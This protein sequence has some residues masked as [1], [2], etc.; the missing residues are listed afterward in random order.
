MFQ[1]LS[2][3]LSNTIYYFWST[4]NPLHPNISMHILHTVLSCADRENLF[5][6]Q[7]VLQFIIIAFILITL[8]FDLG[9][10]LKGEI[11]DSSHYQGLKG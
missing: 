10:I 4:I 1:E 2:F 3:F 9:V 11:I 8:M 5:N 7:E 6:N